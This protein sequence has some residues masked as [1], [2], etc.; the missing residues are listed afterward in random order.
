M[1]RAG[2]EHEVRFAAMVAASA[3]AIRAAWPAFLLAWVA[4]GLL[5]AAPRLLR[6]AHVLGAVRV[7]DP[8]QT[9]ISLAVGAVVAAVS[10]LLIRYLLE[11]RATAMRLDLRLAGYVGLIVAWNLISVGVTLA[12]WAD[13][14]GWPSG[15]ILQH[16]LTRQAALI[17]LQLV[18]V[19]LALWPIGVLLG[20]RLSP[21][22]AVRLMGQA[23]GSFLLAAI[24]LALPVIL[25]APLTIMSRHVLTSPVDRLWQ[26]VLSSLTT[27]ASTF[28]LAQVYSRRLRGADLTASGST[29]GAAAAV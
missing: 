1:D 6:P 26:V 23:Y 2:S 3:R 18:A 7:F 17:A 27:T 11:P 9:A 10:G 15:A 29:V 28:V 4:R 25:L 24:L 13:P 20:D 22:R 12:L 14:R 8:A 16:M 21:L 5:E 19:A